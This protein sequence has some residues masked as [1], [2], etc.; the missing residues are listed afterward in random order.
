MR[1][2]IT[3]MKGVLRSPLA[4]Q[5]WLLLMAAANGVVPLFYLDRLEARVV[6]GTFLIAA[7]LMFA[8]TARFG[9]TRILG[10]AHAPWLV[11]LPY[12]LT[13]LGDV[14]AGDLFGVWLR[15]VI[16]VNGISLLFDAA[17][18]IRYARGERTPIVDGL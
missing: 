14:P 17:D 6:L 2:F 16:V 8:L 15:G 10:L 4:I 9:F 1:G 12:L 3:F 13:R 11:L 18:M 5:L 7:T